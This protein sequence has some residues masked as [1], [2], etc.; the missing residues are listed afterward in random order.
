NSPKP[1]NQAQNQ[2]SPS[3]TPSPGGGVSRI[4][5]RFLAYRFSG[6][7]NPSLEYRSSVQQFS[8]DPNPTPLPYNPNPHR[9]LPMLLENTNNPIRLIVGADHHQPYSHIERPIHLALRHLPLLPH[10]PPASRRLR[11]PCQVRSKP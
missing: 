11:Q 8:V 2:K 5:G 1:G 3:W 7:C 6:L 10:H 4:T 9:D